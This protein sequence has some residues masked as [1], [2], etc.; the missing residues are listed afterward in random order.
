M[1]PPP[2]GDELPVD[3]VPASGGVR[4]WRTIH[5]ATVPARGASTTFGLRWGYPTRGRSQAVQQV[6]HTLDYSVR[7]RAGRNAVE[8]D[9]ARGRAPR[10]TACA[11][12]S[13]AVMS[14]SL[15]WV[16]STTSASSPVVSGMP[17]AAI[18]SR[19]TAVE[20]RNTGLPAW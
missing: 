11:A 15:A 1:A 10:R 8:V 20:N 6:S 7:T 12:R 9:L 3:L 17:A 5:P 16:T 4:A 2:A 13:R 19:I 14:I 18:R